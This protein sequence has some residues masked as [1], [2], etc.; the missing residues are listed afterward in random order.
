[1][2]E[3][4]TGFL[5]G[6]SGKARSGKNTIANIMRI[7]LTDKS[8][9][10]ANGVINILE[11]IDGFNTSIELQSFAEPIKKIAAILLKVP[12]YYLESGKFKS[13][14]IK[15]K[16][17]RANILYMEEDGSMI[18]ALKK[19]LNSSEDIVI[20]RSGKFDQVRISKEYFTARRLMQLIGTEFGREM[21]NEDI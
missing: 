19:P 14:P 9:H 2:V 6:I 12:P 18:K 1:M 16:W 21:I 10:T 8:V 15:D 4:K 3:S 5:I 13:A 11:Y 20:P 17:I 7:L